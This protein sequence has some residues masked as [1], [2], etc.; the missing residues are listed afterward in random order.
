M[1][2]ME[3]DTTDLETA[4]Q[5]YADLIPDLIDVLL[6]GVGKDGHIASLFPNNAALPLTDPGS[7]GVEKCYM[8][9]G[10]RIN[11]KYFLIKFRICD[12]CLRF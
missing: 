4:T 12:L 1:F 10:Y 9:A 11:R 7:F 2:R 6:L 3:A 8:V 5:R